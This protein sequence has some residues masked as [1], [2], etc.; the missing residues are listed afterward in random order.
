MQITSVLEFL[1]DHGTKRKSV[2]FGFGGGACASRN[3]GSLLSCLACMAG[4]MFGRGG[5]GESPHTIFTTPFGVGVGCEFGFFPRSVFHPIG[6]A[7][8]VVLAVPLHLCRFPTGCSVG[9]L[10]H[11]PFSSFS[12]PQLVITGVG[13]ALASLT[14]CHMSYGK[15]LF[16]RAACTRRRLDGHR[17]WWALHFNVEGS[18]AFRF[19]AV[20]VTPSV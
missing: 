19:R 6:F 8:G 3:T 9:W 14:S 1:T 17:K 12:S 15:S 20:V 5:G 4:V 16:M 18:A 11:P 10:S 13:D 7:G 2:P